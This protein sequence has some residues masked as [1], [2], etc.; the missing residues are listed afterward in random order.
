MRS[1]LANL[2]KT[3]L[4][5]NSGNLFRLEDRN[6]IHLGHHDGLSTNEFCFQLREPIFKEHFDDLS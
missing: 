1:S 4:N 5:Q 6:F 2:L 3:K